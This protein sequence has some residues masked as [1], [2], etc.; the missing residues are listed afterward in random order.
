[1]ASG[2]LNEALDTVKS[3][4]RV[5]PTGRINSIIQQVSEGSSL[6]NAIAAE[7]E[8]ILGTAKSLVQS[9]PDQMIGRGLKE[10]GRQV[11][12]GAFDMGRAVSKA[13]EGTS[14]GQAVN[15]AV[16]TVSL[17]HRAFTDPKVT[18]TEMEQLGRSAF[19]TADNLSSMVG[20]AKGLKA[21]Q[22]VEKLPDV[23]YN[24]EVSVKTSGKK[25][26]V[27]KPQTS[28]VLVEGENARSM[29]TTLA[30]PQGR[31]LLS[32]LAD[33]A[34]ALKNAKGAIQ[35]MGV[36]G[37][38]VGGKVLEA[39][40]F[41]KKHPTKL[42]NGNG[43]DGFSTNS[44]T[45]AGAA[46]ESKATMKTGNQPVMNSSKVQGARTPTVQGTPDYVDAQAKR[47]ATSG[48]PDLAQT[49]K[50][51]R[52]STN[53]TNLI[54]SLNGDGRVRVVN[55][56]T[57]QE[58]VRSGGQAMGGGVA[59]SGVVKPYLSTGESAAL[60]A[61][62]FGILVP[63]LKS[64]SGA[65]PQ[66]GRS[67]GD[68]VYRTA[69]SEAATPSRS[70]AGPKP[71]PRSLSMANSAQAKPVPVTAANQ[72]KLQALLSPTNLRKA[73][74]VAS[75]PSYR[76]TKR[77]SVT[78][79]A[80]TTRTP[81]R[82]PVSQPTPSVAVNQPVRFAPAVTPTTVSQARPAV[83]KAPTGQPSLAVVRSRPVT[84]RRTIAPAPATQARP[85]AQPARAKP[86]TVPARVL[87]PKPSPAHTSRPNPYT[88]SWSRGRM[89]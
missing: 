45:G 52:Q 78:Q 73:A 21:V 75:K 34:T 19:N 58:A 41:D 23:H 12:S 40:G 2:A 80:Q 85:V 25:V 44:S 33:E 57:V 11:S 46:V 77:P 30:G 47:Y 56:K 31:N 29:A 48:D 53:R 51:M 71:T 8:D 42:M 86:T 22:T 43:L 10:V 17:G 36:I 62:A 82:A 26:T 39:L 14:V 4:A 32:S 79:A 13:I 70:T 35:K 66:G 18:E 6:K 83:A 88:T 60:A 84:V 67:G 49:G 68:P 3:M 5:T 63:G 69:P 74:V 55:G 64:G 54:S 7:V 24:T 28:Q 20:L 61:G 27:G 1:M 16:N 81:A 72:V 15:D 87:Q 50:D 76:F 9:T 59:E 89:F 65:S 38:K 37:E